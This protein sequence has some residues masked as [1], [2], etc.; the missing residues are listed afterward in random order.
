MSEALPFWP[1]CMR[2]DKAAAYLDIKPTAFRQHVAP[3][4]RAVHPTPG[5]VAYLREDLDAY[6]DRQAGRVAASEESNPW[7]T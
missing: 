1:R 7:P 5:S 2:A 3:N 4:L 6:L